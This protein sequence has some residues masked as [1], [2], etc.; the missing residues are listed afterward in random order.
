MSRFL[1]LV[2]LVLLAVLA[3]A[4]SAQAQCSGSCNYGYCSGSSCVCYPGASGANCENSPCSPTNPCQNGGICD[5]PYYVNPYV[6][7][8]FY[9]CT[10]LAGF[11]GVTCQTNINECASNPCQNGGTC[12]D[13]VNSYTCNCLAGYTGVNCQ[14]AASTTT[15]LGATT[16][17][18]TTT[19]ML[20]ES[21]TST[22]TTTSTL[23][24]STT[25]ATTATTTS[26]TSTLPENTGFV[27][28]DKNADTC[29][30]K[31]VKAVGALAVSVT[32]CHVKLGSA[33]FKQVPFD[34]EACE[35][36]AKVKFDTIVAK[37]TPICPA[38]ALAN[39]GSFRDLV[40]SFLDAH[41]GLAFC[42]GSTPLP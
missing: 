35:T 29:E 18:T 11:M 25:T 36:A 26:T 12:T 9:T 38:C 33:A 3:I 1:P 23:S 41:N 28:P 4:A 27:P 6:D 32:K 22:T 8:G 5:Y 17:S 30:G 42:A 14:T 10:C 39:A 40:E 16:T 37:L 15:T 21:T 31:I 24:T 19:T 2:R 7:N 20:S 13:G 34:E